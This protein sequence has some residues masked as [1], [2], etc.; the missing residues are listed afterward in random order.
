MAKRTIDMVSPNRTQGP[1]YPPMVRQGSLY[2]LTFDEVQ[3]QLG[4]TGKP[5]HS[6]NL[7]ELQKNVISAESG[8]LV[9]TPSSDHSFILGNIGLNGTLSNKT[10][11]EVWRGIVHQEH[12][13]KS[14]DTHMR[15]PS[16]GETTLEDFLAR[17]GVIHVGNQDDV[18]VIG[19]TQPLM[20]I[21]PMVMPSQHEHWMQMQMQMQMH[22]PAIN[23]NP[24]Q[25]QHQHQH[26]QIIGL[27]PDF[28]VTKSEYENPVMDIGYSENSLAISMSSACSDSKSAIVGKKNKYSD[29]VLEKTIER[30]QKRMAKNR[31]SAA[32]SR[33]KKQVSTKTQACG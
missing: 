24:Q 25:Q 17:A 8:Q 12:V 28:S 2:N 18:D 33:A 15:Q 26:E 30:R 19:D 11:S 14:V 31:E 20:G 5:H 4:N 1:Q 6:L 32:R 27:C 29:E 21:D 3:S 9:E 22:I 10:V 13:N 23:I 7:D 16:L